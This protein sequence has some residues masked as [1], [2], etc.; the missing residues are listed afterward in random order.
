M[1]FPPLAMGSP[2]R[3]FSRKKLSFLR[4]IVRLKKTPTWPVHSSILHCS[5]RGVELEPVASCPTSIID[6]FWPVEGQEL[7]R[8]S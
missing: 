7:I 2:N 6:L 3:T 8:I 5:E 4:L 1:C